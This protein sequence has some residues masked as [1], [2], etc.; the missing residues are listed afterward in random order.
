MPR[1]HK[2]VNSERSR[3]EFVNQ[4]YRDFEEHK[5]VTYRWLIGAEDTKTQ[6][7]LYH[8]WLKEYAAF[9]LKI[10][11]KDVSKEMVEGTKKG[12]KE[13]FYQETGNSFMVY[14][15]I[16]PWH[17]DGEETAYTSCSDWSPGDFYLVLNWLQ[18]KA[19][20]DGLVLESKG[21]YAKNKRNEIS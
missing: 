17:S 18:I 15:P 20:Q 14:K 9:I 6:K 1:P 21:Q 2:I 8:I 7:A 4:I 5:Y 10:P 11:K 16:N 19:G 13:M 12:T 3:D